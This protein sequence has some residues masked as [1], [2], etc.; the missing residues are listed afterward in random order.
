MQSNN[1]IVSPTIFNYT[2]LSAYVW[3]RGY[4][5]LRY[6]WGFWIIRSCCGLA[7][8]AKGRNERRPFDENAF[9][10]A[11]F[12]GEGGVGG[13]GVEDC[14]QLTMAPQRSGSNKR[15]A[16]IPHLLENRSNFF[17]SLSFS[18]RSWCARTATDWSGHLCG[19]SD[20]NCLRGPRGNLSLNRPS[21]G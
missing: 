17:L 19:G 7:S 21:I 1:A 20:L 8:I 11:D 5:I 16:I 18:L 6:S 9:A 15:G 3:L 10:V 12:T 2:N 13:G 14:V 4:F